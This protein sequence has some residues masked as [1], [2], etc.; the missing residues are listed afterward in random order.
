MNKRKFTEY[1][2]CEPILQIPLP[3]EIESLLLTT[4]RIHIV[5][6]INQ[7]SAYRVI[8]ALQAMNYEKDPIY[9]YI[10]SPGG[11]LDAGFAIIDQ[12]SLMNCDVYTIIMGQAAS[13]GAIIAAFGKKGCRYATQSSTIM[14]HPI[15]TGIGLESIEVHKQTSDF[16][17]KNSEMKWKMIAKRLNDVSYEQII[18]EVQHTKWMC[19]EEA[20]KLGIIDGIWNKK[21]ERETMPDV[22]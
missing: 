16:M 1:E 4:R 12:I 17:A 5:G 8:G 20:R 22:L 18:D 9:L 6:Q 7:F 14:L 21:M 11:E 19:P 10:C 13:M 3:H 2:E 15:R